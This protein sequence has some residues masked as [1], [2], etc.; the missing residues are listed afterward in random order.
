M[1]DRPRFS[2]DARLP[3]V[4]Y[5]ARFDLFQAGPRDLMSLGNFLL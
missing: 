5:S 1:Q 3:A 4:G 2:C